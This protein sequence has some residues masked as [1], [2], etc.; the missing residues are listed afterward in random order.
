M[1]MSMMVRLNPFRHI[2]IL[3]DWVFD[4]S[5]RLY[6]FF[7]TNPGSSGIIPNNKTDIL[8]D[9]TEL[10]RMIDRFTNIV[11][12]TVK[13]YKVLLT[14][15]SLSTAKDLQRSLDKTSDQ[16][17]SV[18]TTA[19]TNGGL[20]TDLKSIGV[21]FDNIWKNGWMSIKRDLTR[22]RKSIE[23]NTRIA[24]YN[25]TNLFLS[26][27]DMLEQSLKATSSKLQK[28]LLS[29]L[30]DYKGV[31]FRF[32]AAVYVFHLKLGKFELEAVHSFDQLG[33]CSKFKDA[34]KIF[35]N[36]NSFRFIGISTAEYV[37]LGFFLHLDAGGGF[38]M[39]FSIDSDKIMVQLHAQASV[40]GIKTSADVL[41]NNE[42]IRFYAEG[43]IWNSFK[44]KLTASA[45]HKN[46]W[47]E[48]TFRVH[49]ELLG[50]ADKDENFD[51]SYIDA[52]QKLLADMGDS[53]THRITQVQRALKRAESGLTA[54]QNWLESKKSVV[55]SANSAFDSAVRKMDRAKDALERA[56]GPFKYAIAKLHQAQRK[57]DR[58]CRIKTCRVDCVPG[59]RCKTRW[60]GWLPYPRC[61]TT[62]CM[63]SIPNPICVL[64][65]IGCRAI[66]AIAYGALEAAKWLVKAPMLALDAAKV[67]VSVAQVVVDKSR[68]VLD[69]AVGALDLA[70]VGLEGAKY[71]FRG[72][73][74]VLEGVKKVV[75]IGVKVVNFILKYGVQSLID[76]K[77]CNFDI[78]ISTKNLPVF[79]V[80]CDINPFRLGWIPIRF[81]VNFNRP[82]QSLWESAKV[83]VKAITDIV[84][85]SV[86][87]RK[88]RELLPK[89][90]FK[91]H[92]IIRSYEDVD[93]DVDSYLNETIDI[94]F[95]TAGFENATF[96]EDYENRVAIF[97]RRCKQF[98]QIVSFLDD[99]NNVLLNITNDTYTTL[100][101][102][103]DMYD[104]LET[105][106]IDK[107]RSNFSLNNSGINPTVAFREFNISQAQLEIALKNANETLKNDSLLS[108][109]QSVSQ[110]SKIYIKASSKTVESIRMLDQWIAAM[111]NVTLEY[112]T[113]D[114]CVSFLDCAHYSI[115][116]LLGLYYAEEFN[117]V[118]NTKP[119]LFS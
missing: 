105:F 92:K 27:R 65:N 44:A 86:F 58:L 26:E 52:L 12:T 11:V 51:D 50:N 63:F 82:I 96:D 109:I 13:N 71:T 116:E 100:K 97:R 101:A 6:V 14:N 115:A 95:E 73:S 94:V 21:S 80:G 110:I 23:F 78:V 4:F 55:R 102:A 90:L 89:A 88:K 67:A 31:G 29:I 3:E 40:L 33:A 104:Q 22:F 59:L 76:V 79:A 9:F 117:N 43:K 72:A 24:K 20:N 25:L 103:S 16:L 10:T 66:R 83:T 7:M 84:K 64:R 106:D 118:N 19:I 46:S 48:L 49:G 5:T 39:A 60:F 107:I 68:V 15:Q 61:S 69:I 93:I 85:R 8:L 54:A 81:T 37:K 113:S 111:D 57:V 91:T 114:V 47:N 62:S 45:V 99:A 30:S 119:D 98:Q 87:G 74:L 38:G 36:K 34:F 35:E 56:K 17:K 53:A 2:P 1:F 41:I 75:Q 32:T 77:N 42:G 112:Y 18:Q 28:E 70:K 108:E